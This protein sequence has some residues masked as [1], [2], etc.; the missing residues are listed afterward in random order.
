MFAYN[1]KQCKKMIVGGYIN[2][3]NEH[4]CNETCYKLYCGI[5]GYEVHLE[6]LKKVEYF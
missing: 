5:Y 6:K 2:E 1:C 4:F 3:F